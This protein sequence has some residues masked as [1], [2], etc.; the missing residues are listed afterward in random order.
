M[1]FYVNL[2]REEANLAFSIKR[3]VW[4]H[5]WPFLIE[6]LAFFSN[7]FG[8]FWPFVTEGLAFFEKISLQPCFVYL[9]VEHR[10]SGD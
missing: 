10:R 9:S 2:S 4:A 8:C 3:R 6:S 7:F 5:F 1:R